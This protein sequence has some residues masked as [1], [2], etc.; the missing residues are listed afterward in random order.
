MALWLRGVRLALLLAQTVQKSLVQRTPILRRTSSS[1]WQKRACLTAADHAGL[2]A[3]LVHAPAWGE[4]GC[5]VA[6]AAMC[7]HLV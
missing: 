2:F 6:W 4:N 7:A 1:E 5:F 3:V